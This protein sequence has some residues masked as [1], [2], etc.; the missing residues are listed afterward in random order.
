[1]TLENEIKD[2]LYNNL[3]GLYNNDQVHL[4]VF[5]EGKGTFPSREELINF[6]PGLFIYYRL[7]SL[8]DE[9]KIGKEDI[10]REELRKILNSVKDLSKEVYA[11]FGKDLLTIYFFGKE[12]LIKTNIG[13][14]YKFKCKYGY[15]LG[16]DFTFQYGKFDF[17]SPK[18]VKKEPSLS[19]EGIAKICEKIVNQTPNI[20]N[21]L[22]D[23]KLGN[24]E[25]MKALKRE[26]AYLDKRDDI[27]NGIK[28]PTLRKMLK[29]VFNQQEHHSKDNDREL[30]WN[31]KNIFVRRKEDEF[32]K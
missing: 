6:G 27:I 23:P 2:V 5:R 24:E 20:I 18:R 17:F 29:Q 32:F 26:N 31:G 4:N 1:M 8:E 19:E 7:P 14:Y 11:W 22:L 30:Y 28:D 25:L 21:L 13:G 15:K 16:E 9:I 3:C 12:E 10:R